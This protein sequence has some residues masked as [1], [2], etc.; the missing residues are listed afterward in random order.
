MNE[1]PKDKSGWRIP[2][3]ISITLAILATLIAI[4]YAE[5]DWRGKHA[6]EK[7]KRELEAKGMVLDWEKFIPPPVPDDQNFFMA[8]TNILLRFHKAQTDAESA[9]AT[10]SSWLRITY[11]T[12]SFPVFDTAKTGPLV[13]AEM[14]V[15]SS[16]TATPS[17]GGS[18]SLVVKLSAADARKQLQDLIRR[19]VGRG[20][21]GA[22]GFRFS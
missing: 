15:E 11:S 14:M 17:A 16:A 5:E 3:R 21:A 13:V 8:S 22:A 19:T 20:V 9:A 2:R 12:N 7:C 18:H 4:F 1:T 6:W 10:Q